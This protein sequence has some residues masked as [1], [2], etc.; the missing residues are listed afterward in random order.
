MRLPLLPRA[1]AR[2]RGLQAQASDTWT[3]RR[4]P[5]E[6]LVWAA[7][8]RLP[9]AC[10]LLYSPDTDPRGVSWSKTLATREADS[11]W[12]RG[13]LAACTRVV[14]RCSEKRMDKG[15]ISKEFRDMEKHGKDS[16]VNASLV[17]DDLTHWK[18]TL[19][20]PVR[21]ALSVIQRARTIVM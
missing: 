4:T 21:T 17:G 11:S 8:A 14:E 3:T 15:R 10:A 6:S 18:G 7:C 5:L 2:E 20:G 16:P 13:A 19:R 12:R 9:T 1:A